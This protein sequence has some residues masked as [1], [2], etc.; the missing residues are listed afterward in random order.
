MTSFSYVWEY[1]VPAESEAEFLRHYAPD[2]T[3]AGLF[4]RAQGYRGTQLYR[5]RRRAGRYVTVD[6][7][8]DETAY[9]EFR[10]AFAAE[11]EALDRACAGLTRH[12]AHLGDLEPVAGQAAPEVE[13]IVPILRVRDLKDS[14][15]YYVDVLG[16]QAEWGGEE[17]ST[18]A[19]VGRDGRSIMLCEGAQGQPGT[20]VWIGMEDILP[21]YRRASGRGAKIRQQPE[22]RPWAYE[23]QV[24]DPDGHVLRF[25]SEPLPEAR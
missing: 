14:L 21:L 3:W 23:M 6:H 12:E 16:F 5:D 22:N 10:R 20:W 15:R 19:S 13:C 24:E 18:I 2:G 9:L 4:G 7:W 11:F 25:G 17:G 8:A 1:E